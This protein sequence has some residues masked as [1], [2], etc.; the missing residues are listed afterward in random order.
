[1]KN[2]T[3][4][5]PLKGGVDHFNAGRL[6]AAE[7]AFRQ[8]LERSPDHPDAL[9][10][11]GLTLSRMG[12]NEDGAEHVR[13]ALDKQPGNSA[14]RKNLGQILMQLRDIEGANECYER[15]LAAEPGDI[16]A[17]IQS[18]ILK[19][20]AGDVEGGDER[21]RRAATAAPADPRPRYNL[22]V[23]RLENGEPEK[24]AEY[25]RETVYL[26]PKNWE[27][28]LNWGRALTDLGKSDAALDVYRQAVELQPN[29]PLVL[30]NLGLALLG[31]D[32]LETSIE[33]LQRAIQAAPKFVEAHCNLGLV[34]RRAGRL[35]EAERVLVR[36]L[37]LDPKSEKGLATLGT[38]RF[39]Q[40]EL[41][42]AWDF[43][44]RRFERP[45]FGGRYAAWPLWRGEDLAGKVL[46]VWGDQGVGDEIL[47]ASMLPDLAASGGRVL[48]HCDD[49]MVPVY[50]RSLPAVTA[51]SRNADPEAAAG[52]P[53]DFQIPLEGLGAFFR[54]T[55]DSIPG[56]P[57]I[58][59]AD[60]DLTRKKRAAYRGD[61]DVTLVGVS[62][63]STNRELGK[64]KAIDLARFSALP[65][66]PGVRLIDLQYGD[67]TE[68]RAAFERE[69]G[70]A[71]LHDDDFDQLQ[72][73]ES[74]AAQVA[75]MDAV[76]SVSSTTAHFAGGLGVPAFVMLNTAPLHYWFLD[77]ED[78]PWYPSLRLFRQ[79]QRGQ[80]DDVLAAVGE[81][82]QSAIDDTGSP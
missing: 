47:F 49:R 72:D 21:L 58:I 54:A 29:N 38:I 37:E 65:L 52:S 16:D 6:E 60:P 44:C 79:R 43:R 7:A 74:F 3:N 59:T 11:L 40:G 22:G 13:R 28:Y 56:K 80:W 71:I 32:S 68:Q 82:L 64:D 19:A 12:R 70:H 15:V 61:D 33:Y 62:W 36:A 63:L 24:A 46:L 53:I 66:G 8:A 81:A 39:M 18:G 51:V 1:M 4:P 73:L 14:F 26:A 67:T 5:L 41:A 76:V 57:S 50:G 35:E 27:A 34:Y 9:H 42:E 55:I 75:A 45:G 23:M 25:F 69:T 77:R 31:E 20:M 78:S 17:L 2:D 10:L 30:N 48:F